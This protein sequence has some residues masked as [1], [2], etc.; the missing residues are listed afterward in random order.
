M[1]DSSLSYL[2][3]SMENLLGELEQLMQTVSLANLV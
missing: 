3:V 1:L 2:A